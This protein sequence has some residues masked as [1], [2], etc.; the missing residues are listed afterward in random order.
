MAT[1]QQKVRAVEEFQFTRTI[2]SDPSSWPTW[3]QASLNRNQRLDNSIF[4][5]QPGKS[6]DGY[7]LLTSYGVFPI[8]EDYWLIQEPFTRDL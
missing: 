3:A 6:T 2:A 8:E 7:S 1:Y 5:T 4:Y